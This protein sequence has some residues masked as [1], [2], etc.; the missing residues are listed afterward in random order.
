MHINALVELNIQTLCVGMLGV[1]W[2]L[3]GEADTRKLQCLN[4]PRWLRA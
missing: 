4:E 1:L 2:A 3:V